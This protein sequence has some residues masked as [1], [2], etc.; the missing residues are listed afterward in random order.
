MVARP[1]P[2]SRTTPI[3]VGEDDK[4]IT[5]I[6]TMHGPTTRARQLNLHVRSYLVNCILELRLDV[7]DVLMIR[8]L[9]RGQGPIFREVG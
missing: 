4:D 5:P 8:N 1:P 3:Q 7:M 9:E 6:L 2:E